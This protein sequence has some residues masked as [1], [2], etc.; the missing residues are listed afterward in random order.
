MAIS[1]YAAWMLGQEA[2]SLL[3]RLARVRPFALIEPMVPAAALSPASQSAI[4]AHLAQG[5][6]E[7]RRLVDGYLAWLRSPAGRNGSAA[8][9]QRRFTVLRLKFNATLAQFDLFNHSNSVN[10]NYSRL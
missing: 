10:W 2:R 6:R 9:G 8:E 1:A 5:R 4:E 7:L 3:A